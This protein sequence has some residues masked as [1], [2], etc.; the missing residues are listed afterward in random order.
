MGLGR[1]GSG[2]GVP[3]KPDYGREGMVDIYREGV[4]S[5]SRAIRILR[6]RDCLALDC[7]N[8]QRHRKC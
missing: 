1:S 6:N 3:E 5:L 4:A 8:Q 7:R 2:H